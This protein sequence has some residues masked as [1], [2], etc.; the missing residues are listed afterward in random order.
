MIGLDAKIEVL[1][2]RFASKLFADVAGNSYASL[3]RAFLLKRDGKDVPE[4]QIASTRRY[5]EVLPNRKIDGQSFFLAETGIDIGNDLIAKV[6]I[7][8]AVNL[9]A[10]YPDVT[11]RAVEYLHRDVVKII[12]GF[13]F[14]LTHIETDLPAFDKFESIKETD[15]MQPHYLCRFDTEIDYKI[16]CNN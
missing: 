6:S 11:E 15:N 2:E 9:D 14:D 13:S 8:F 12:K 3:G 5:Q 7:Y 10:L 16:N 4:L 1:R